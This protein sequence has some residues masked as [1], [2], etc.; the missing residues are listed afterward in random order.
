MLL[1]IQ[2]TKQKFPSKEK[3]M[4]EVSE[5]PNGKK[6]VS[7]NFSSL[8]VIHDC[9]RKSQYLLIQK[10]KS[11]TE[12][13][14][15]LFGSAIH[16]GLEHWYCLPESE[17]T[18]SD[19]ESKLAPT[20]I[21]AKEGDAPYV[22]PLESI[23]QFSLKA[24]PL[25]WLADGDKRSIENGIKILKAYFK[26][27]ADDGLEVVCDANGP[28]VE[29]LV[30]FK[31][32]EDPTVIIN[33][34]G[35]ID[36]VVRNKVSGK[37][38]VCDHKTTATLGSQFYNRIKPNHQYTGY[39]LAAQKALGI[40]TNLFMVNGIQVAKTKAEFARQVTDRNQEDFNEFTAAVVDGV[41]RILGAMESDN[42]PMS[43][44]NSCSN[45]GSCSYL[46]ICSSPA[47]LRDTIISAKYGGSNV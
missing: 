35:T 26:H 20:L 2:D 31:L 3:R 41:Y 40:D 15:T 8:S 36:M 46:D 45:Y 19:T 21:H 47:S 1:E 10:L 22:G 37:I 23:R 18:L 6:V 13:E 4:L 43:A 16:K 38:M 17:R 28:I 29:R 12:S 27:Y 7:I 11:N 9:L 44:P 34:H 24:Q 32:Y 5:L 30:E 42:F 25:K 39:I 14:A 33:F